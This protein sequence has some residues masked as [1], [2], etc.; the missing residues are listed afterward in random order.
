MSRSIK[1]L[2]LAGLVVGVAACSPRPTMYKVVA[3]EP[4]SVEP[5]FTG[6]YK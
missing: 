5:A 4:I 1:L 6:K 3:P 2:A